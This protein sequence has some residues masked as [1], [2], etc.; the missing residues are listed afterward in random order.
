MKPTTGVKYPPGS[1]KRHKPEPVGRRPFWMLGA[2]Q[3]KPLYM[4]TADPVVVSAR[5]KKNKVARKQRKV[6]RR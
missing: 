1:D 6:N 5:R 3:F 4:G 2:L